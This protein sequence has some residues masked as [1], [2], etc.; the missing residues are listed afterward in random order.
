[1]VERIRAQNR[2]LIF[3]LTTG[4]GGQLTP[5]EHD[6][7]V[8]APGSTLRYPRTAWR[9][10]SRSSLTFV[11]SIL[12]DSPARKS[13]DLPVVQGAQCFDFFKACATAFS[14]TQHEKSSA[15]AVR[16]TDPWDGRWGHITDRQRAVTSHEL[17]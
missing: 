12:R 15:L 6:P 3:N 7:K 16:P 13:I 9:T 11:R 17:N 2:D 4:E 8:A 14:L 5:S 10:L 1:V